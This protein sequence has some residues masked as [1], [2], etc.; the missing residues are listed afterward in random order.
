MSSVLH[1]SYS[2]FWNYIR[3]HSFCWVQWPRGLR[4]GSAAAR[5]LGFWERACL[6]LVSVVCCHVAVSAIGW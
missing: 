6:S 5:L 2:V 1:F 4:C 3:I